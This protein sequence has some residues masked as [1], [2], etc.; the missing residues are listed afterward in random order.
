MA[1]K[2]QTT[3]VLMISSKGESFRRCGFGF[4]R[5]PIGI[6]MDALTEEQIETLRNEPNLIVQE[7]EFDESAGEAEE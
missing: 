2:K 4:T 7:G 6:A 5:E 1:K 3:A